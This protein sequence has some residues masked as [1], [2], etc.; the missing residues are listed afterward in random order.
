MLGSIVSPP[1]KRNGKRHL[2]GVSLASRWWSAFRGILDFLPSNQLKK[3]KKKKQKKNAR[4]SDFSRTPPPKLS[5][6][7]HELQSMKSLQ[8]HEIK[9][10][11]LT[12]LK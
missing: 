1:A 4:L 11:L 9:Y 5:D 6:S 2:H 8:Q 7:A 10:A 3:K 12:R